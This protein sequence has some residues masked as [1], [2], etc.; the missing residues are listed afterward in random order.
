MNNYF[1][2]EMKRYNHLCSE[3]DGA[4]H[5]MSV[6]LGLSDSA[7][8]ILYTICDAGDS[9]LLQEICLRSGISKQTIN[10]AIRKLEAEGIL[11]LE[12]AGAK[13]KNV[14]FTEKGKALA[15]Q[16]AVRMIEAENEIFADWPREDVEQ[17]LALTERYLQAIQKKAKEM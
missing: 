17:Y 9:C 10:S 6:K 2:K 5:E 12:A 13:N 3:I 16:T 11:Y 14:R 4:Y 1:S 8:R 7:M 15:K